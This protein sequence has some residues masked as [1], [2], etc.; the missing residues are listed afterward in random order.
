MAWPIMDR[1]KVRLRVLA[2]IDE[3]NGV[4]EVHDLPIPDRLAAIRASRRIARDRTL[5]IY[6]AQLHPIRDRG[7]VIL[8]APLRDTTWHLVVPALHRAE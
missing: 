3:R 2:A 6:D 8:A 1:A 5:A 7:I 4:I